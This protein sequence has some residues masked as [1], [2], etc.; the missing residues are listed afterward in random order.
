MT[1]YLSGKITGD[2]EYKAK[3]EAAARELEKQGHTVLNPAALPSSGF[4]WS[5]YMRIAAAML[6]ECEAVYFLTDWQESKGAMQERQ[7]ALRLGKRIWG[8]GK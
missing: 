2:P 1:I 6:A 8:S 7:L 5:A 4:E 3:F